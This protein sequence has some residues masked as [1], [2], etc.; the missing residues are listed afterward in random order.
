MPKKHLILPMLLTPLE[1]TVEDKIDTKECTRKDN[2]VKMYF[3]ATIEKKLYTTL[4]NCRAFVEM[5]SHLSAYLE[6]NALRRSLVS[7]TTFSQT[8]TTVRG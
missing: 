6:Q 2:V 1:A 5:G 7:N 3:C 4:F 8:R